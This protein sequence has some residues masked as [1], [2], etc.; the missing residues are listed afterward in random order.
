MPRATW[1]RGRRFFFFWTTVFH[2]RASVCL[3]P[4]RAFFDLFLTLDVVN[5]VG[6]LHIQCDRFPSQRFQEYRV[7]SVQKI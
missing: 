1:T 6:F 4:K 5:R 3:V 7:E 2:L